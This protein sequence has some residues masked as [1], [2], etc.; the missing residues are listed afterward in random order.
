MHASK[1]INKINLL[2]LSYYIPYSESS[3]ISLFPMIIIII[4]FFLL[5]LNGYPKK[6]NNIL[7]LINI[8]INI[9]QASIK[10]QSK[11]HLAKNK[12]QIK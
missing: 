6:Y 12:N 11:I 1:Q 9:N 10:N 3:I 7:K 5:V 2:F 4:L 8:Y